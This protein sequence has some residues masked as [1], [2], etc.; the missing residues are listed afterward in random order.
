MAEWAESGNSRQAAA[1]AH[2]DR[3]GQKF[4]DM[5]RPASSQAL[6]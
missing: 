6:N 1:T 5:W 3:D 4:G 2:S